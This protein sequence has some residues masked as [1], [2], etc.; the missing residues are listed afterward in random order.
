MKITII[1]CTYNSAKYLEKNIQS[2]EKQTYKNFEHIFIDGFSTDGT[3]D[4]IEKYQHGHSDKVF[5]YKL[6]PK[7]IS[8][9]MNEGIKKATGKYLIHLHSDDYFFDN[10]VLQDLINFLEKNN[11]PDWI[12]GKIN[13]LKD[14]ESIGIY[15]NKKLFK[16]KK[17]GR[18]FKKF[19]LKIHNFIPHQSVFIK[20]EVFKKFG[21]FDENLKT[22]MDFDMWIRI[23]NKTN[24]IFFDRIISNYTIRK[25]AQSSGL[26]NKECNNKELNMIRKKYLNIFDLIVLFFIKLLLIFK[27]NNYQK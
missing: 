9:A 10:Y 20:K 7:G 11:Y 22:F 17:R 5:F 23:K 12:Y 2:V 6:T 18:F 8:N 26:K 21:Y 15:P 3:T 24:F 1:T 13:V 14:Y 16:L 27:K 25:D 4:I 19:I